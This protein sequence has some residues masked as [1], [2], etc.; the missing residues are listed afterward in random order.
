[1]RDSIL[2]KIWERLIV[3]ICKKIIQKI[4]KNYILKE[5]FKTEVQ[6]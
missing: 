2:T 5:I 4:C 1:M 3:T 6:L